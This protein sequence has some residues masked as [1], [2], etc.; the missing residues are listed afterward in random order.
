MLVNFMEGSFHGAARQLS[1]LVS[2]FKSHMYCSSLTS[3][4]NIILLFR[5]CRKLIAG[6]EAL[7]Q[8]DYLETMRFICVRLPKQYDMHSCGWQ[9]CYNAKLIVDR[10]FGKIGRASCR[11]R[12]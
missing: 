3:L 5:S 9:V 6:L 11:E 4:F 12:V 7:T 10:L 2:N 1:M 8:E